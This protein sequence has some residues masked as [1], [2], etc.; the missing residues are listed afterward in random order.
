MH[1]TRRLAWERGREQSKLWQLLAFGERMAQSAA[2]TFAYELVACRGLN[3][4]GF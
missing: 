1:A 3:D 4:P 2:S